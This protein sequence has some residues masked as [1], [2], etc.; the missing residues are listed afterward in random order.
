[1]KTYGLIILT[2]ILCVLGYRMTSNSA[3]PL[4]NT[5][6][7]ATITVQ[8]VSM[9]EAVKAWQEQKVLFIDVRTLEEYRQGYIPG[10]VLIPLDELDKRMDE[11]PKDKKVLIICRSGNRSA[12]ANLLLQEQGFTNTASVKGGMSVWPDRIEK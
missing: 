6:D 7:T 3:S 8:E 5:T 10:A 1:M 11:V 9:K 2:V 4:F 12:T